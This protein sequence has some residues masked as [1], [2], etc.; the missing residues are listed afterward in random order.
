MLSPPKKRHSLHSNVQA[1][2]VQLPKNLPAFSLQA[3]SEDADD[4]L[5]PHRPM[6]NAPSG[7]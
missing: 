2:I 3:A 5:Q 7:R 1:T 4:E 6:P